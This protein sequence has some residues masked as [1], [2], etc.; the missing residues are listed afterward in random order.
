MTAWGT[1]VVTPPVRLL[2]RWIC[3]G[4]MH[5]TL[6][7]TACAAKHAARLS[8]VVPRRTSGVDQRPVRDLSAACQRRT[9]RAVPVG[10]GA[11]RAPMPTMGSSDP[12]A[13]VDRSARKALP[14]RPVSTV[15]L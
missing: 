8:R 4:V 2:Q 10:I 5:L 14:T 7:Y 3:C 9:R 12:L 15:P 13:R 1:L 11:R 6:P